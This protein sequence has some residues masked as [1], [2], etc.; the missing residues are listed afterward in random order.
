MEENKTIINFSVRNQILVFIM[1][2][3]VSTSCKTDKKQA[4]FTDLSKNVIEVL[5]FYG[6]HRCTSC[7]QIE[8]NTKA[9]LNT[10]FSKEL[11]NKQIVFKMVQ[12]DNPQND[13]LVEKYEAAGTSLIIHKIKNG[14][15][16]IKDLTD[17]AFKK[18]EHPN[19]F[20]KMLKDVILEELKN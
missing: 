18:C 3:M 10:F 11:K 2:I 6:K 15:E 1:I 12:W 19:A 20:S 17:I 14:K 16:T 9:T 4:S 5:D 13:A 8:Q 7:V